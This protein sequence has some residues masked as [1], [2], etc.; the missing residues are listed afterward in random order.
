MTLELTAPDAGVNQR[1]ATF[2]ATVDSA[3]RVVLRGEL[4]HCGIDGLRAVLD[5]ALFEPGDILVD[6]ESLSFIDSSAL[7]ELLRYQLLAASQ[8]RLLRL[9]RLSAPVAI[10]LDVHDLGH[11]LAPPFDSE[12][13]DPR[14][15]W[16]TDCDS[17]QTPAIPT[18]SPIQG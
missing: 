4:D 14:Q 18:V 13:N 2:T 6:V 3:G 11:L 16:N 15:F 8:Q 17:P 5:Q 10:V 9:V 12:S 1:D 7:T